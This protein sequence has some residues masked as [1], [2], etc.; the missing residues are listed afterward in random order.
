MSALVAYNSKAEV[1]ELAATQRKQY[2]IYSILLEIFPY[3]LQLHPLALSLGW[4][5]GGVR[6][7]LPNSLGF[8]FSVFLIW[9]EILVVVG[10]G[11]E[12]FLPPV[13]LQNPLVP[14]PIYER[15]FIYSTF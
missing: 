3:L 4:G 2:K 12:V 7:G 6:V 5:W 13:H 14:L 1:V 15:H 9:V 11:V 10:V 8:W